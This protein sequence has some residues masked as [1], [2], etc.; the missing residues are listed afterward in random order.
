M[1]KVACQKQ[2]TSQ[3]SNEK[4]LAI[5]FNC[6]T[7]LQPRGFISV[8]QLRDQFPNQNYV[9][10]HG[11]AQGRRSQFQSVCGSMPRWSV[12]KIIYYNYV[13]QPSH[14]VAKCIVQFNSWT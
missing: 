3:L 14:I 8:G 4:T 6:A 13:D 9:C 1:A 2:W 12:Q 7:T 10:A 5:D 11:F